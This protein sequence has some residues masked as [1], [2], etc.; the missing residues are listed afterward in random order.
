MLLGALGQ[1][2]PHEVVRAWGTVAGKGPG[3]TGPGGP[4]VDMNNPGL[5]WKFTYRERLLEV[6]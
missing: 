6:V 3:R 5:H 2:Q 1:K 4:T